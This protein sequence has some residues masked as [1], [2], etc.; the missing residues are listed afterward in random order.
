MKYHITPKAIK[1][2]MTGHFKQI[3]PDW[4]FT[5]ILIGKSVGEKVAFGEMEYEV[6]NVE[7]NIY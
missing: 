3:L 4:G 1:V 2:E 5:Q 7:K 6:V